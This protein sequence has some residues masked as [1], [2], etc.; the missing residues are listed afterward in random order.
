MQESRCRGHLIGSLPNAKSAHRPFPAGNSSR[1]IH[2]D[3][4]FDS[5]YNMADLDSDAKSV[6]GGSSM[7]NNNHE[8]K[9]PHCGKVFQVDESGYAAIVQQV[10][11]H[12]F[13]K[14]VDM[15]KAHYEAELRSAINAAASEKKA[16]V[17]EIAAE[18]RA[19]E[20]IIKASEDANKAERENA[21]I[22]AE[23]EKAQAV[24]AAKAEIQQADAARI[25]ELERSLSTAEADRKLAVSE[26]ERIAREQ[27][28]A[29]AAELTE[30]RHQ[31]EQKDAAH[32]MELQAVQSEHEILIRQK[33]EEIAFHKDLKI[34]QSTK[35]VG[36][37]LEQHCEISF[38]QV[39]AMG[40]PRAYFE[41]DNDASDGSKGDYIFRDYDEEGLE[42]I[43][44]MFEMKNEMDDTAVKH[45]NEDFFKKLDKDR[46]AKN[47]EY[48]VL[49]SML[50][51]DSDLYNAG[52]VDVSYRYPKMYVIRPQFF[53]P[54]ITLLRNAARNSLSYRHE[55]EQV[56]NQ[57]LDVQ[58][59]SDALTDFK[60]RFGK[61]YDLASRKFQEAIDSIDKSIKQLEK[62]KQALLSSENN[63]RLANNKA[64]ELTIKRLVKN[65]PTMRQRFEES[66]VEIK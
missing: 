1:R 63:L 4:L 56:R 14:S 5:V 8:I 13:Q 40:F 48:A 60:D 15:Q 29:S 47:C 31:L 54:L 3:P 22:A 12:E 38:N 37:T 23:A 43:S 32:Q 9:C 61:N 34:R 33:D 42:Y 64:E 27:L 39:R 51:A 19:L 24:L 2:I 62:T 11:D 35:M 36:E 10:R 50:E 21:A 49:V 25:A 46:T 18:K 59:F 53:I 66:G 17:A 58:A 6:W 52:I 57:N 65:N 30:L 41:K 26:A 45:K 28:A 7:P 20:A 16:A 44:I 55:L